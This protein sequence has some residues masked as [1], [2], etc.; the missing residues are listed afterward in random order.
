MMVCAHKDSV[1]NRHVMY[2]SYMLF[3]IIGSYGLGLHYAITDEFVDTTYCAE[4]QTEDECKQM[5]RI[6]IYA[7]WT[8]SILVEVYFVSQLLAW[9]KRPLKKYDDNFS[10]LDKNIS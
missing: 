9:A 3:C 8:L 1:L 7:S 2:A 6:V 10:H 4:D 5:Q